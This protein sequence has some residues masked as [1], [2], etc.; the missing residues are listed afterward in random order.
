VPAATAALLNA[1]VFAQTMSYDYLYQK[2]H[3]DTDIG[4]LVV[5]AG[6]AAGMA[7][8]ADALVPSL[9]G[10]DVIPDEDAA[11]DAAS[12]ADALAAVAAYL[13]QARLAHLTSGA[14]PSASQED[15]K[16]FVDDLVAAS[17]RRPELF[18]N[19]GVM[20]NTTANVRMTL[21]RCVASSH[22]TATLRRRHWTRMVELHEAAY[23]RQHPS[24]QQ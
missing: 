15:E 2:V 17:K 21:A 16:Y 12:G 6:G 3:V 9:C 24:Q 4:A 10:I 14:G 13:R 5:A 7:A 23:D 11:A 22:G 20:H 18:N 19:S 1:T 8:A